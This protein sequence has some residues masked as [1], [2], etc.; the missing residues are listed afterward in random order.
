MGWMVLVEVGLVVVV[1]QLCFVT[2]PVLVPILVA[3]EPVMMDSVVVVLCGGE[4]DDSRCTLHV[5][6]LTYVEGNLRLRSHKRI[7]LLNGQFYETLYCVVSVG[8]NH[9]V[10]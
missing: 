4:E 1:K 3:G 5:T 8:I 10:I 9:D 6:L 7:S 2:L